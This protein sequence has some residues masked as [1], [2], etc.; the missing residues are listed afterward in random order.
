MAS[1]TNLRTSLSGGPSRIFR[2][3]NQEVYDRGRTASSD[4]LLLAQ[5]VRNVEKLTRNSREKFGRSEDQL[6][7][8]KIVRNVEKIDP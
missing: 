3:P 5:I 4:Q 1:D 2:V 8:A 7:L 6:L